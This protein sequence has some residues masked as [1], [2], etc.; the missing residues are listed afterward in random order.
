M[1]KIFFRKFSATG[2][3]FLVLETDPAILLPETRRKL[4]HKIEG[5]SADG[6][7]AITP[8]GKATFE[9][10][11]W[12]ADG[13]A[14]SFCGNGAR[15]A[16][17]LAYEATGHKELWLHFGKNRYPAYLLHAAPPVA[18]VGLQVHQP[19]YQVALQ[20]PSIA[21]Q[22][23]WLADTGSPHAL[24]PVEAD[25]LEK[26]NIATWALQLMPELAPLLGQSPEKGINV[27]FFASKGTQEYTLRTYE[28]GVWDETLS[29]GTASV[30]LAAVLKDTTPIK[31]HT[32]GGELT[33]RQERG[34]FWLAG[35]LE[36]VLR[37]T[38]ECA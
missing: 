35:P 8:L 5:L 14:G 22:E 31:I 15:V 19:P 34:L 20:V 33:V 12:N 3:T 13:Q 9:M 25:Q 7:L 16:T 17:W 24:L 11:Y 4:C 10:R 23:A 2:N 37:G 26:L 32:R 30:A 29:C 6:L 21:I 36:E 18:E 28:R 1:P 38:V 27:S